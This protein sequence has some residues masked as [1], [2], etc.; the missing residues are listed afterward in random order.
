MPHQPHAGA[1]AAV[2]G[3][4]EVLTCKEVGIAAI[5]LLSAHLCSEL[6][7]IYMERSLL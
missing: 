7:T 5:E 4:L 1:G 6:G 2:T 3:G